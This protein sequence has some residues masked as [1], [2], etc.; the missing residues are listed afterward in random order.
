MSEFDFGPTQQE[1]D[2]AMTELAQR[3]LADWQR[4]AVR[5]HPSAQPFMD[6]LQGASE[7][8]VLDLAADLAK[9]QGQGGQETGQPTS[10]ATR[11]DGETKAPASGAQPTSADIRQGFKDGTYHRG[12]PDAAASF[13]TAKL[14]EAVDGAA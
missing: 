8:E 11:G 14:A 5:A 10:T 1:V 3:R 13:F 4:A 6:L 7:S 2:A 9:R 12:D